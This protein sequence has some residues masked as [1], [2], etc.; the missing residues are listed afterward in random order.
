MNTAGTTAATRAPVVA[1]QFY[2]ASAQKL[3]EEV[4]AYL[5][6]GTKRS[7]RTLLAMAPHAGYMY[8]GQT[9]GCTFGSSNLS[10]TIYLLG[11]N[12]TGRGA[13]IS[14]WSG[15]SWET[16]LGAVPIDMHARDQLLASNSFFEADTL[17]HIGEHSL[18]VLLPFIQIAAPKARIVPVAIATSNQETLAFA[19]TVLASALQ[20]NPDS[21]IVV[22]SDM[23][24]YVSAEAAKKMDT[25]ALSYVQSIDAQG[26]LS[27]VV[28]NNISM[29]GVL[30]MTVGLIACEALGATQAEIVEYTN[31]GAVTGDSSQVVGYAGAIIDRP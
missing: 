13:P 12:H 7:A 6:R 2:T 20:Q 11:P 19:G 29:C 22:S 14:V 18:E 10:N 4:E 31:S 26:L 27:T 17:A 16:P 8:S 3:R 5:Q 25:L 28:R 24:H 30:P 1:G 9:A 21:C 15:G 23:S